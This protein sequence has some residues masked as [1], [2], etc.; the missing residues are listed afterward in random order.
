[1]KKLLKYFLTYIITL[2]TLLLLQNLVLRIPNNLIEKNIKE[3]TKYLLTQEDR[4]TLIKN[5][6]EYIVEST[7]I[8]NYTDSLTLNMIWN[9]TNKTQIQMNYYYDGN[10]GINSLN[11]TINNNQKSNTEYSRYYQGQIIFTKL[12]LI[13][14]N[15]KEIRIIN[16]IVITMLTIYLTY[17]LFKKS[18]KLAICLLLGLISINIFLVPT[19]IQFTNTFFIMLIISIITIKTIKKDDSFF[20]Q[21]MIVSGILTNFMDFL[22]TE[23]LTLTIP[24]LI[25]IYLKNKSKKKLK[26]KDELLFILKSYLSWGISYIL[27]FIIK[28]LMSVCIYGIKEVTNIWNKAKIRIYDIPSNNK[29][30]YILGTILKSISLLLPFSLFSISP[31]ISIIMLMFT[32]WL[33]IFNLSKKRQK[34]FALL[35]I[36]SL[37]PII[38]F[39][40]LHA[41]TAV[42]IYFTYRGLLPT[43]TLLLLIL[44]ESLIKKIIKSFHN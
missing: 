37:V 25:R 10:S 8:D 6:N 21:L 1:M 26:V 2:G 13:F 3:S 41:H 28:W 15:I 12:L 11:E 19:T 20:Y 7:R 34:L 18:K 22:T 32:V 29:I 23:T 24:L 39:A 27:S 36:I 31:V 5:K 9:N 40:I 43:I 35:F 4:P 30:T 33:F 42:H 44:Y 14:F 17:I 38:R 16:Y